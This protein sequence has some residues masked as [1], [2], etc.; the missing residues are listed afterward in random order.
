MPECTHTFWRL[1]LFGS[2]SLLSVLKL[3][4]CKRR[5]ISSAVTFSDFIYFPNSWFLR[6]KWCSYGASTAECSC[7][8]TNFFKPFCVQGDL[9]CN[10]FCFCNRTWVNLIQMLAG[11]KKIGMSGNFTKKRFSRAVFIQCN[12]L[13]GCPFSMN[14]SHPDI[15][16]SVYSHKITSA[17]FIWQE[18]TSFPSWMSMWIH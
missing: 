3:Y 18:I 13:F 17:C 10:F 5:V 6:L 7:F 14:F 16:F 8:Q 2:Q 15:L 12:F 11:R 1:V 4:Y 9:I